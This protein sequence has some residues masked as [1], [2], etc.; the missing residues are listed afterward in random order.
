[1]LGGASKQ[2]V[3]VLATLWYMEVCSEVPACPAQAYF[4]NL[5]CTTITVLDL[6]A[7]VVLN[8]IFT[9]IAPK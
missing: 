4:V 7:S 2:D 5:Y 8:T 1:M 6:L 9:S 3:L